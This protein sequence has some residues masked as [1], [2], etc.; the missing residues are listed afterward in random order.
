MALSL[1]VATPELDQDKLIEAMMHD[2]KT[3]HGKLRFV[4]PTNLGNV[5][6]VEGANLSEVRAALRGY[7]A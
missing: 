4:L 3:T 1:P 6:L 7:A 2:K 5:T